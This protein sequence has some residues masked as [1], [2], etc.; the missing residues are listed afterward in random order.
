MKRSNWLNFLLL[1]GLLVLLAL[2][3]GPFWLVL[4]SSF[5]QAA[6]I[7]APQ[8]TFWP[9]S[10]TLDHYYK[11][12]ATSPY[13]RYLGNSLIV[14]GSSTVIVMVLAAPAAYA[15]FRLKFIGREFFY[16]LIL[17]TYAFPSIVILIPLFGMMAKLGLIDTLIALILVNIAFALPFSIWM[18][19]SFF[20]TVPKEIEEAALMDGASPV[21]ILTLIM[22]PLIAPGIASVAIFAFITSWTEYVFAS[23]LI[24]SDVKRTLPVGFSGM[25]GQ[26]QIDWGLLLAGAGLAVLPV[27]VLFAFV[28]RW[29][30]SGLTEGAIK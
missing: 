11:L 13:L 2:I 20:A 19:R 7:I 30:V 27:V 18:L 1:L 22:L 6:E 12:I 10:F 25:I 21:K 3:A 16:R 8:P 29:F 5:K 24:I 4:T 28:A 9:H 26:Y 14:A 15:F 23:V 17:L